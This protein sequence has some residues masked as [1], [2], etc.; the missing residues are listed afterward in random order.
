MKPEDMEIDYIFTGRERIIDGPA[1]VKIK[2][3]PTGLTLECTDYDK[4]LENMADAINRLIDLVD[5]VEGT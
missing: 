2:H 1:G 4:Q 3:K 5:P